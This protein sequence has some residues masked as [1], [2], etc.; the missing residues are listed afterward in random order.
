MLKKRGLVRTPE[1]VKVFLCVC[2]VRIKFKKLHCAVNES[3][4]IYQCENAL[5]GHSMSIYF[6][7]TVCLNFMALSR[8]DDIV[9]DFTWKANAF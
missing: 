9:E 4:T 1:V 5:S 2:I 8:T 7:F 3:V 6:L